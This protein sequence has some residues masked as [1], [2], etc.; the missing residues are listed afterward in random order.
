MFF[1]F[2]FLKKSTEFIKLKFKVNF[3]CLLEVIINEKRRNH[4]L[5]HLP[6]HNFGVTWRDKKVAMYCIT[7]QLKLVDILAVIYINL[8]EYNFNFLDTTVLQNYFK[9]KSQ[10]P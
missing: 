4:L 2:R 5:I 7:Y 1:D 6:T 9:G 8:F 3:S 10:C